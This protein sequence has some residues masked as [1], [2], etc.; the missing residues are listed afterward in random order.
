MNIARFEP[1]TF[2]D[3]LHRDLDR[4]ADRRGVARDDQSAVA[5]WVP[6][7]DILEEDNRFLLRADV[8]GVVPEDINV[9]MDSGVLN[10][11]GE[12][13]A[14]TRDENA[15]VQRIERATGRFFRHF[16]LPETADAE[17]ISAKC[18]NGILEVSIPKAPEIQAR[19]ITV[20][21]A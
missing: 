18:S 21:A 6:A 11:S 4:L 17:S 8:P 3:L 16:T 2:V 14:E 20:E 13:R 19:R 9:S 12:R 10:I 5:D 7:V 1:W 15:G